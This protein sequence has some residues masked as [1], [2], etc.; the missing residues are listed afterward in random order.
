MELKVTKENFIGGNS[1]FVVKEQNG[2]TLVFKTE[3]GIG[4]IDIFN[5][6]AWESDSELYFEDVNSYFKTNDLKEALLVLLG[7]CM[8]DDA[9]RTT[10][11]V[12]TDNLQECLL[13]DIR[14]LGGI[15]MVDHP[16][17]GVFEAYL[18]NNDACFKFSI[19]YEING[20]AIRSSVIKLESLY[21]IQ[22]KVRVPMRLQFIV[23]DMVET[24]ISLTRA[25]NSEVVITKMI[26][27]I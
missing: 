12:T 17:D 7:T 25:M 5:S 24:G 2:S 19:H 8:Y 23:T 11:D 14:Y 4:A 3:T 10:T 1:F 6:L 13:D 16:S 9:D 22:G 15:Y 20:R 27:S 21:T 26:D 18:G